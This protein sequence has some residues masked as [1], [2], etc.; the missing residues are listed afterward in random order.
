MVTVIGVL[1]LIF[2]LICGGMSLGWAGSWSMLQRDPEKLAAQAEVMVRRGVEMQ[3]EVSE[4][5]E[6]IVRVMKESL[7]PETMR[8]ALIEVGRS[9]ATP[10]IRTATMVA[11]LAQA[12][13]LLGSILLLMRKN[14]GRVLSILALLAFIGATVA[15][16]FKFSDPA[17]RIAKEIRTKV[18]ASEGYRG[19]S[20]EDRRRLDLGLSVLPSG[21]HTGVGGTSVFAMAWPAVSLIILLASRSIKDACAPRGPA[22]T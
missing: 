9:P 20:E 5:D 11:G 10:A 16:M 1:N 19:L 15:T 4:E 13:L 17:E 18:E 21:I 8:D 7:T 12:A 14:A 22:G 6:R 2:S 3:V